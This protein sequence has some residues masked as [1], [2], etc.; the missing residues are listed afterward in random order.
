MPSPLE[1]LK[2]AVGQNDQR[3]KEIFMARDAYNIGVAAGVRGAPLYS[4]WGLG[5]YYGFV[6]KK[7]DAINISGKTKHLVEIGK[8]KDLGSPGSLQY[9]LDFV[10][11]AFRGFSTFY[12]TLSSAGR[13]DR[14]PSTLVRLTPHKGIVSTISAHAQHIDIIYNAFATHIHQ[15]NLLKD[16]VTFEDFMREMTKFLF[17]TVNE[18]PITR[19]GF[20]K[21]IFIDP[22]CSGLL[23]SI[24]STPH[25]RDT[26]KVEDYYLNPNFE[27]YKETANNFGF[28]V[29]GNA[30]WRLIAKVTSPRMQQYM[31]QNGYSD[32]IF[33]SGLYWRSAEV[34]LS[35]L[36]DH[37]LVMYN[38][39]AR[40]RRQVIGYS[41][42]TKCKGPNPLTPG[43][44]NIVENVRRNITITQA[45][46][47]FNNFY[48]AKLCFKLRLIEEGLQF[49]EDYVSTTTREAFA[50]GKGGQNTVDFSKVMMY[51][52]AQV[53]Q[54]RFATQGQR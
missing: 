22:H 31:E 43:K 44:L 25:D 39:L 52:D 8:L 46:K 1:I 17:D 14:S 41:I 27:T 37:M 42:N 29:D 23:V 48:W 51:L 4:M 30:P 35:L 50:I 18:I 13:I 11:D 2:L 38:F 36:K 32:E 21:S 26:K 33:K 53:K 54:R 6:N 28:A 5:R 20:T 15:N 10:V 9:G 40:I 45:E 3:A 16:I 47:K 12:N 49:S 7:F 34:D 24:G 19:S